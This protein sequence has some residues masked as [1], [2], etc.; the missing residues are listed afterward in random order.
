MSQMPVPERTFELPPGYDGLAEA[1]RL[2]RTIR[3][4]SLASLDASGAPFASLVNVATAFD[5]AP[6]L[7][8]SGLLLLPLPAVQAVPAGPLPSLLHVTPALHHT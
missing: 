8:L 2:L 7:L 4:G 1:R 6:L 3:A 5:G